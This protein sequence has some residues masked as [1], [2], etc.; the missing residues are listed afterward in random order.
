MPNFNT[1][2][3]VSITRIVHEIGLE[4]KYVFIFATVCLLPWR[5][6]DWYKN[7]SQPKV[8]YLNPISQMSCFALNYVVLRHC[9]G[10]DENPTQIIESIKSIYFVIEINIHNEQ[11]SSINWMKFCTL[12]YLCINIL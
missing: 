7:S 8:D 6:N 5:R 2:M 1:Y 3:C 4:F 9:I 11:S 10:E 12:H